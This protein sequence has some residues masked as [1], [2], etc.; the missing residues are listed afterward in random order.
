MTKII[1]LLHF[2]VL[3]VA[4]VGGATT[5]RANNAK[6]PT[7]KDW[8]EAEQQARA[9]V[10]K[11]T[12]SEKVGIVT[13]DPGDPDIALGSGPC[14][15]SVRAIERVG[16]GGICLQDGPTAVNRHQLVSIFPAGVTTAATWDRD[17]MFER[18]VALGQ[19]F[20]DKGI[21]V[22]L[23]P[24]VGPIGRHPLAGRNWE[25]FSPDPYLSGEAV[26]VSVLGS[27]SVGVQTCAKHLIG[28]EQETHR[29]AISS[30]IDD[31]TLHELYL[32]PFAD[33]VKAG[34]TSIMTGHNRLN[35]TYCSEN[36]KLL[37]SILRDE[38]GFRGYVMSDWWGTHSTAS[39]ANAGLDMEQPGVATPRDEVYWGALLEAAVKKGDVS[40][41]RLDSMAR[42][43]LA[44]YFL[45]RQNSRGYPSVDAA[46]GS[47]YPKNRDVRRNHAKLIREIGAAGTVLLKNENNFLPLTSKVKKLNIGIFGNDAGE[48]ADSLAFPGWSPAP[49]PEFGTLT[50]GGGAGAGRHSNIVA[51]LEAIK[52]RARETGSLVQYILNNELLAQTGGSSLTGQHVLDTIQPVPDVCLVFLKT[53]MAEAWDRE[54]LENDWNSTLVVNNVAN[55]CPGKT[56][57]ITHSGGVNIYPWANN[58]NVTAILAAHYP[59]EESGNSIVD[60]LWGDAE[61]SGRLPYTIPKSAKDHDVPIVN[62]EDGQ[63][64]FTEGL[65]I[66]YRHFDANDIEPLYEFGFGLGYTKFELSGRLTVEKLSGSKGKVSP[67]PA[68]TPKIAPGG[69]P[70]LWTELVRVSATVKNAGGRK[71]YGGKK[72]FTFTLTRRDLSYWDVEAQIWRIPAG[73]FELGV[74][75]SSRDVRDKASVK[76]L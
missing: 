23:G 20:R 69:H 44:P 48:P 53:F 14:I 28:N 54:E 16:F 59:G 72:S 71:G 61:P 66:D 39:S 57:V 51:P 25:S 10:S 68:K 34:T 58:P 43:I 37:T 73:E 60:V 27:Q 7:V 18:S 9:L 45:M 4:L 12:L 5:S 26:R 70:D 8:D 64:E 36:K 74:G 17:L 11:L 13:G 38:L 62:E 46:T 75:F 29:N 2:L 42:A 19:E 31:R 32:W 47:G 65:Y 33:A 1:T 67:T 6:P 22:L 3:P 52:A 49:G 30:N 56:V 40:K 41:S 63:S 76:L 21:H 35:G 24:S 55:V 50:I 15:G